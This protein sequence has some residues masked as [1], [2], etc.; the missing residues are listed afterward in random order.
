MPR[1][2]P[3]DLVF[4]PIADERFPP[5][6]NALG[7]ADPRD[8]DRFLL[9]RQVVQLIH[10]LRPDD[11][12]G[13]EIGQ[14]AALIHHAYLFWD[15]GTPTLVLSPA[16]LAALLHAGTAPAAVPGAAPPPAYYAQ[17]PERRVWARAI[18]AA[19]PEPLDGCFMFADGTGAELHVLSAFGLRS[20]RMGLTVVEVAGPRAGALARPD[21][22][23]LFGPE[24]KGGA[25]A[26]LA[27]V[28]GGEE[29][30]ELGWRTHV[31]AGERS[32]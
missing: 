5:I 4:A 20:E 21:G 32:A 7:G 13:E 14:L 16:D 26:G 2:T 31:L 24:L 22:S 12:L 8:R 17:V 27:S 30:L 15:A 11:G 19:P 23:A 1:P 6:R 29:L 10:D 3:F 28:A 25:A 18:P 9:L